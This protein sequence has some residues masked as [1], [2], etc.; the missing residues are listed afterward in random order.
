VKRT[1]IVASATV[2]VGTTAVVV[3]ANGQR[4]KRRATPSNTT[5]IALERRARVWKLTARNGVRFVENKARGIR[6]T[7]ARKAELDQQFVIRSAQD[8]ANELG[9]MKGAIMKA[10]QLV[11]FILEALPEEA[12]QALATLQS[13]APPMAPSLAAQVILEEL[14]TAPEKLFL[15]WNPV[16]VAAASVGQVHKAVLHDGRVVAVK[17]QY[18][19]VGD[20]IGAD[21]DN[22]EVLYSIFGAFALKGLDTKALVEELRVR[23]IEELDYR[24]EAKNQQE[25]ADY[26]R[27]HPFI[28]IPSVVPE[29][30]RSRVITSEW[31]E[32]MSWTEFLSTADDA[33]KQ[34]AA[35]VLWR[36]T[37]GSVHRLGA[38]NG[39]PHPGNYRFHADG[40]VTFLDFGL[41]KRWSP[42][43]WEHLSPNIDAILAGDPDEL[44]RVMEA[45]T[46]L[47]P[48]HGLDPQSIYDYVSTP[49][50]PFLTETFAFDRSFV[51]DAMS[52]ILDLNGPHAKV[53]EHLNLP[54]SFVIL[55]RVV[56]G[57]SALQGKLGAVGPWRQMLGEYRTP[58]SPPATEFGVA[59][60]AWRLANHR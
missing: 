16:P 11:S 28:R 18:P 48:G 43:E 14:G 51:K 24:L 34:R 59:D 12:Q 36:F 39:D 15:D 3:A 44:V 41:V 5:R 2:A 19:G 29:Y 10:G 38:F 45:T 55:D 52:T 32:G 58:G 30:S 25:F 49:Y 20:A 23:M 47:K 50:R 35:E 53:I 33:A 54:V 46:F 7:D 13:D 40:T 57:I 8:V 60:A 1:T 4:I 31:V 17:V 22:V 42:G 27:D 26:Y 9:Q 56:W 37:Q 6:A 21:L